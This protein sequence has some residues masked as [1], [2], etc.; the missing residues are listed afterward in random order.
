MS[1]RAAARFRPGSIGDKNV[2]LVFGREENKE[3]TL[4]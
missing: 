3:R 1:M 4:A 2:T